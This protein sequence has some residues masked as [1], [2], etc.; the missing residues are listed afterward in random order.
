MKDARCWAARP[1]LLYAREGEPLRVCLA[2]LAHGHAR[3]F[4]SR[5]LARPD[6]KLL[7][8]SESDSALRAKYL[9]NFK[10][11]AGIGFDS[12]D[13]MLAKVKPE[14]VLLFTN[15]F[16]HLAAV[17]TCA[18]NKIPVVME[19][20]LAVSNDH[21]K[22]MQS[23]AVQR[24]AFRSWSTMKRPGMPVTMPPAISYAKAASGR[25]VKSYS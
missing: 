19:K 20:P 8:V 10:L 3:G 14:V 12:L 11:D 23:A 25:F 22:R 7:G 18:K 24:P 5:N 17:Q 4:F 9:N 15:T 16:D 1:R 13:S 21:A 6:L 2:G